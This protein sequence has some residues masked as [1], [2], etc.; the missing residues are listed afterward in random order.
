MTEETIDPGLKGNNQIKEAIAVFHQNPN[1]E[2]LAFV[3]T[4]VRKRMKDGG[5]LVVG[6]E[7]YQDPFPVAEEEKKLQV[8]TVISRDGK[9]WF[10]VYTS[11]EEQRKGGEEI[12]STF[13]TPISKVLAFALEAEGV[14]GLMINPWGK[15][16]GLTKRMAEIVLGRNL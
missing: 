2:G 9:K 16:F 10:A 3:L 14:E 13:L 6:V 4:K 15:T 12:N 8:Q 11:F 5:E 1:D 7:L